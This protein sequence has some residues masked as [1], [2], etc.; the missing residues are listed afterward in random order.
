MKAKRVFG[1]YP[2]DDRSVTGRRPQR[3]GGIR[4]P[5]INT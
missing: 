3:I 4:R 1:W 2:L 5:E